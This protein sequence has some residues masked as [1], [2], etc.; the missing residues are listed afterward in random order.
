MLKFLIKCSRT[1]Y[2]IIK[3]QKRRK[4]YMQIFFRIWHEQFLCVGFLLLKFMYIIKY[5]N[6]FSFLFIF[7]FFACLKI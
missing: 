3:E 1:K 4:K 5:L 2:V 6:R 7:F